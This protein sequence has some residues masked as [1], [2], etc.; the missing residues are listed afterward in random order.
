MKGKKRCKILKEIRQQIAQNNDI[1]FITSECKHQ[2]DCPGTCPKCEAEVRYLERELEKRMK[3][4][5]AVAVAGLAVALTT[6]TVGCDDLFDGIGETGSELPPKEYEQEHAGTPIDWKAQEIYALQGV[7]SWQ[8]LPSFFISQGYAE[9][10]LSHLVILEVTQEDVFAEWGVARVLATPEQRSEI[11]DLPLGYREEPVVVTL[12]YD[13]DNKLVKYELTEDDGNVP[14]LFTVVRRGEEWARELLFG[15]DTREVIPEDWW[16][17]SVHLDDNGVA[18]V[19]TENG[20]NVSI[21]VQYG[22]RYVITGVEFDEA[23]VPGLWEIAQKGEDWAREQ[24]VGYDM[25]VFWDVWTYAC[26]TVDY[27]DAGYLFEW[28]YEGQEKLLLLIENDIEKVA[29][30][31]LGDAYISNMKKLMEQGQEAMLEALVKSNISRDLLRKVWYSA[32]N[33][34]QSC[35]DYDVYLAKDWTSG[36][37]KVQAAIRVYVDSDGKIVNVEI[38]PTQTGGI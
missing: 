3:L 17:Y 4:G 15:K 30:V 34:E 19:Y 7:P 14:D 36:S 33:A 10:L 2:G 12:F 18:F 13:E 27:T 21:Y 24:L 26:D 9:K 28:V 11:Y 37:G 8:E 1:E 35:E 22:R 20:F 16:N 5:K 38:D 32:Y 6:S 31:L 23:L 25:S 29:D